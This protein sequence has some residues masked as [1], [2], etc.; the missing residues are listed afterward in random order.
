MKTIFT[1]AIF[2]ILGLTV[3]FSQTYN[4]TSSVDYFGNTNTVYS[5]SYGSTVSTSITS[6][7]YFGNDNTTY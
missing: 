6:T 2:F 3:A 5:D 4:S 7:D 1:T